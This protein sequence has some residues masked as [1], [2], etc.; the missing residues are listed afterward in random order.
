[1]CRRFSEVFVAMANMTQGCVHWWL[2]FRIFHVK[3]CLG[4]DAMVDACMYFT[5]ISSIYEG[6]LLLS[7]DS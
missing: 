4:N 5:T 1:M 3:N 2:Q 7:R 6:T